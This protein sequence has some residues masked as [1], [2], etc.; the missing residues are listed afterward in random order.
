MKFLYFLILLL[1]SSLVTQSKEV[2]QNK[3]ELVGIN[4]INSRY[5]SNRT[6][7]HTTPIY[8][9]NNIVIYA[10]NFSNNEGFVLVSGDDNAKA[11]IAYSDSGSFDNYSSAEAVNYQIE[12]YGKEIKY[13]RDHNITA[14][15][16]IISQWKNN[17]Y[18]NTKESLNGILP[19]LTTTWSQGC[20][21]NDSTPS[22]QSGN[23][24]HVVTG[25]VATA[26]SQV[27]NYYNFPPVGSGKHSYQSNYGLLSANFGNTNYNWNQMADNLS[28]SSSALEVSSVA[29]LISH[30]GI[31]VDMMYSA[32]SSGAY[33]QDAANSFTHYFNFDNGLKLYSKNNYPDSIWEQMIIKE[34][35]SL[36]PIYYDGNGTGGH[37]FVC[38]GYQ[39]GGY[40]HFNWGWS[41]SYNGYFTLS[42]LN[43]GGMNFSNYCGAVLGMKPGTPNSNLNINDTLTEASGNISDESYSD[44]YLNNSNCSWLISPPNASS[45]KIVFYTFDVFNND[46]VY[47]YDGNDN[48]SPLIGAYSGHNLPNTIYSSGSQ[49]FIQFISNNTDTAAG[50]SASYYS[51]YCQG[52]TILTNST[53]NFSDG[54]GNELYNN[55]TY[56]EWLINDTN[57]NQ[58]ILEFDD[59]KTED[60]YDFVNVYDGNNTNS[61]LLGT[62]SGHNLPPTLVANSGNMLITF[63][64]DG[65]VI[66]EGWNAHYTIC[67][68]PNPPFTNDSSS[69]C[70]GDSVLLKADTLFNNISWFYNGIALQNDTNNYLFAK[71][72]G[73]YY[74]SSFLQGC[75]TLN[76]PIFKL[77]VNDLPLINLGNDTTICIYNNIILDGGNYKSYLWNTGDTISNLTVDSNLVNIY[78][79]S[80][81][82]L[83]TDSNN[84][85]N[86]DT[87]NIIL[88]P[89][90]SIKT[91]NELKE[92]N[93]FPNPATN[94]LWIINLAGKRVDISIIDINGKEVIPNQVKEG[95]TIE[96][97]IKELSSGI[98][99]LMLRQCTNQRLIKFIKQ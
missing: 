42:N 74:Y 68:T 40:F 17:G 58:I 46:S 77:I 39:T 13:I 82:L 14:T 22:D 91:N 65:G 23:C 72:M 67:R 51:E 95:V 10:I 38:D 63:S 97:N 31:S 25:C 37:A 94:N 1:F 3:A 36:R 30:A 71:Q 47:I 21:Y 7:D 52:N 87:T 18:T 11:V 56:C 64:S 73:N 90:L 80:F 45:I 84:C 32:N 62:Y 49:V 34:L 81:W 33:S 98:Y 61:I 93:I 78:G 19:L 5:N 26:M 44:F 89:C 99:Y 27:M 53:G 43:P 85:T 15:P 69:I 24:Q 16:E 92:I 29:Q 20:Y 54:S 41:G 12:E 66:D 59:F 70:L 60:G 76:S 9:K 50:W 57:Q 4:F 96:L 75:S 8:F 79:N 83:A 6:I 35:D 28:A 48:Q 86:S 88:S 55:N 2:S